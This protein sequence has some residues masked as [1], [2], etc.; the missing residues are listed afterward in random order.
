MPKLEATDVLSRLTERLRQLEA[1]EEIAAREIR[2][3]LTPAQ[4]QELEE[5]WRHQQELRKTTSART[6]E[7]QKA[8]GW[9][10]K[11]EVRIEVFRRAR[12]TAW[13]HMG[14]EMEQLAR[15]AELRQAR[16]YFDALTE[17]QV[18][19]KTAQ[20]ARNFANNELTRA[21]LRRMDG[22]LVRGISTRDRAIRQM[23]DALL[24]RF[25]A[26]AT[27]EER[28]QLAL[29]EEHERSLK[30]KSPGPRRRG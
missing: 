27:P 7:E 22:Q 6:V 10:S 15:K 25:K 16:I 4:Q 30:G 2:S 21:D 28:E 19:G 9:K 20:E 11:R 5:G 13:D 24:A 18:L 1:G 26:E 12:Q 3:L 17:A 23:E 29:L 14:P 8:L